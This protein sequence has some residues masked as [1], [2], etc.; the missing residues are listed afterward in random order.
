MVS[1]RVLFRLCAAALL[2]FVLLNVMVARVSRNSLPKAHLRDIANHAQSQV[3]MVGNSVAAAVFDAKAF[4]DSWRSKNGEDIHAFNAGF[5]GSNSVEHYLIGRQ[6]LRLQ[7]ECKT[8]IFGFFDHALTDPTQCPVSKIIGNR[9]VAFLYEPDLAALYLSDSWFDQRVFS[10]LARV[11]L[12]VERGA[13]WGKVE[14]LRRKT[15]GLGMPPEAY[16]KFGRVRDF[17]LVAV[18]DSDTF[19]KRCS[20]AV[21]GNAEIAPVLVALFSEVM[22]AGK[23]IR[24]VALPVSPDHRKGRYNT[25]EWGAYCHHLERRLAAFDCRIEYADD[26]LTADKFA[27]HLHPNPLGAAEFSSRLA[28]E[29]S[30]WRPNRPGAPLSSPK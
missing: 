8:V 1:R 28:T 3:T 19:K 15:G 23:S 21:S 16:N 10:V 12:Y 6:V 2:A 29:W 25:A 22:A 17:S 9:T 27:D 18:P 4:E 7:P 14:L 13:Y 20:D 26:W 30:D 24:I 11:P 5:G